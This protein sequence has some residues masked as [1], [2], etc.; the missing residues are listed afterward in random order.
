MSVYT[1]ICPEFTFYCVYG[2][3]STQVYPLNFLETAIEDKQEGDNVF[4]RRKFT[5]ELKFGGRGLLADW[6]Y[7]YGIKQLSDNCKRIDFTIYKN[8]DVYWKGYISTAHGTW[9]FDEC[10]YSVTPVIEDDYS[11]FLEQ[12]DIEYNILTPDEVAKVSTWFNDGYLTEEYKENRT[13]ISIVEYL[14]GKI[15]AGVTVVS[16]FLKDAVNPIT[17][18]TNRYNLLTLAQKSDIKRPNSTDPATVGMM[19]F[20]QIMAMLRCMQLY[21]EYD[22]STNEITIEHISTFGGVAGIDTRNQKLTQRKNKYTNLSEEIYKY[23]KF[24]WMEAKYFDFVG[25]YISYDDCAGKN[26]NNSTIEYSFPNLTTDLPYIRECMENTDTES[27]ISDDGWVMLANEDIGGTYYILWNYSVKNTAPHLFPNADLT[28]SWLHQCFWKHN[29]QLIE[30]TMNTGAVTFYTAKASKV[31]E[32][33]ITDCEDFDPTEEVITELGQT[34]L[35][36]VNGQVRRASIKPFG[37][38]DLELLYAPPANANPGITYQQ[39]LYLMEYQLTAEPY[40]SRFILMANQPVPAQVDFVFTVE[41]LNNSS[42]TCTSANLTI[43]IPAGD[44]YATV[45]YN[46]WCDPAAVD[47]PYCINDITQISLT[48]GWTFVTGFL[49]GLSEESIC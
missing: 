39:Y 40:S 11:P 27:L 46:P 5:G 36:G 30:G 43:T 8:G 47:Y 6:N 14:G 7:F 33:S 41:I 35:G 18:T 38:I 45:D 10:V 37:Q 16:T 4:Y 19:S 1:C 15:S 9:D 23:E 25:D 49:N 21:W 44:R 34:W 48:A 32:L 22:A 28:W 26:S 3:V 13:I 12:G 24:S 29:R 42:L 2:T 17:L 31:Q 20:N